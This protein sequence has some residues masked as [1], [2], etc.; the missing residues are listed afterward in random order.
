[1]GSTSGTSGNPPATGIGGGGVFVIVLVVLS[2]VVGT[3]SFAFKNAKGHWPWAKEGSVA[4]NYS[5]MNDDG[6]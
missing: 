6:R 3:M 4:D 5:S 2:I 1:M